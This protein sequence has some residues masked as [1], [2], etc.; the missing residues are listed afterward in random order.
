MKATKRSGKV[1]A[2]VIVLVMAAACGGYP[3][4]EPGL[5]SQTRTSPTTVTSAGD[6]NVQGVVVAGVEAGCL[7]LETGGETYLL[8]N[9]DPAVVVPGQR[10][11]I[12]GQPQ[13]GTAT[14][15]MQGTPLVIR[16]AK[17]APT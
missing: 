9:A 6:V 12:R 2:A 7:L 15:C 4:S 13:P 1:C 5:P 3:P 14:T 16:E 17:P 8:L 10:V 11:V